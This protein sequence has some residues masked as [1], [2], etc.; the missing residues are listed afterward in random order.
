MKLKHARVWLGIAVLVGSGL[1]G[2]AWVRPYA[3]ERL[4]GELELRLGELLQGEVRIPK[5]RLSLGWGLRL[6]GEDVQAWP[7]QAGAAE[8]PALRIARITAELRPFAGITGQRQLRF[9]RIEGATLHVARNAE[10]AWTPPPA[11][12]FLA[13]EP[14]RLNPHPDE[15]LQPLVTLEM[16]A[17]GILTGSLLADT[18]ELR[19]GRLLLEDAL[20]AEG[21]RLRQASFDELHGNLER[22]WWSGTELRLRGRLHDPRGDLGSFEVAGEQDRQDELAVGLALSDFDLDVLRPW[23]REFS[24]EARLSGRVRGAANFSSAEP[25][26]ARLELDV[27][28]SDL[29]SRVPESDSGGARPPRRAIPRAEL[30][31]ALAI[32]PGRVG[33]ESLRVFTEPFS[34]ELHG[35]MG[36]PLRQESPSDVALTVQNASLTHLRHLVGWLPEI[37]REEAEGILAPLEHGNVSMLRVGGAASLSG[38][39][40]FLAGRTHRIPH[41]FV[42]DARLSETTL[43]VGETDRLE[44]LRGRL[45]WTGDRLEIRGTT[46]QLNGDSLPELDLSLDGVSHLFATDPEARKRQGEAGALPGLETIWEA[47][48]AEPGADAEPTSPVLFQIERLDHPIFFW[49]LE[50]MSASVSETEGGFEIET[51]GGTLGGA[52]LSGQLEWLFAPEAHVTARLDVAAPAAREVATL[53]PGLWLDARFE[54]AELEAG[55]WRHRTA[56]GRVRAE[57]ESI[58]ISDAEIELAPV[59]RLR[60]RASFDLPSE[61]AVPFELDFEIEEGDVQALGQVVGLPEKLATGRLVSQGSLRGELGPDPVAASLSGSVEFE[62]RDGTLSRS[63]PAVMAVAMASEMV[64][65]FARRETV[66]YDRISARLE[67]ENGRLGTDELALEGP[68]VRA[69]ASGGADLADPEHPLD[70][71]VVLFLFRPM[72]LVLEKIPVVN[73]LLLG[74]DQNLVAAHFDLTGPWNDPRSQMIPHRSFTSGAG[75]LVFERLPSLVRRGLDALDSLFSSGGAADPEPSVADSEP[76]VADQE[77]AIADQEP[78]AAL[79]PTGG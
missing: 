14:Q 9:L 60:G 16:L 44:N 75:S 35:S 4:K 46:A 49:P 22:R 70:V 65:P 59:G 26:H 68:D 53:E 28:A 17:R 78:A 71:E 56:R 57:G 52:P 40:D 47:L 30:R 74:D 8:D 73:Y 61:T 45:W 2:F 15:L 23:L 6:V 29:E 58:L 7:E 20:A 27:V 10:G 48:A 5:L 64:N 11:A 77:P 39:Q 38:W 1:V 79:P 76:S 55:D 37:R 69:L 34:L 42:V 18:L 13:E 36:R 33:I 43:R 41:A 54:S 50:H 62:A 31:G 24:P 25:G 32:A 51:S 12:S 3:P 63:V 72:D 21:S 66:R 67:L 19:N